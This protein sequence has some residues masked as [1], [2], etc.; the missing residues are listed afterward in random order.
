MVIRPA[1]VLLAAMVALLPAGGM[2]Q[3]PAYPFTI[4]AQ[5]LPLNPFDRRQTKVGELTYAGGLRLTAEGTSSFG[6]LSGLDVAA[7]GRL[8][9]QTDT[10]D[11]IRARI[12]LDKA[13]RLAGLTEATIARLTDEQGQTAQKKSAADAEDVTLLTGGGFAIAYEQDHR[14]VAY[15]G[16]GAGRRLAPPPALETLQPNEGVE[17]LAEWRDPATGQ[18]RLVEGAED[19]RAWSCD[20]GGADCRQLLDRAR[21]GPDKDFALTGLDALPGGEGLIAVYRAFSL[22]Q[23]MRGLIAWI[24]PGADK[25]VTELARL[26]VP[27][28]VDNFEGVAAVALPDGGFRLYIVSDDNYSKTQRTLLLAFDWKPGPSRH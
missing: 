17:A 27:L 2:A 16:T 24:R 4:K 5:A 11:L 6:G 20:T 26:A 12:V 21:D 14:I 8:I 23:G 7:D 18:L 19:G 1:S 10:G 28:N 22:F 3:T 13:G 15:T 9:A 25:Q